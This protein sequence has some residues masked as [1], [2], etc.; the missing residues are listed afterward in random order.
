[1]NSV[2]ERRIIQKVAKHLVGLPKVEIFDILFKTE[3]LFGTIEDPDPKIIDAILY[4]WDNPH[5][6]PFDGSFYLLIDYTFNLRLFIASHPVTFLSA[7]RNNYYF[8]TAYSSTP[9]KFTKK[10][11]LKSFKN[12]SMEISVSEFLKRNKLKKWNPETKRFLIL[13]FLHKME[14]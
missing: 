9:K 13:D 3:Q 12:T 10:N 7:F 14:C 6:I 2:K 4:S 8:Q 11:V 5:D 1:M